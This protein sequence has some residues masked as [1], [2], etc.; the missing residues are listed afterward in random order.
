MKLPKRTCSRL[1][2]PRSPAMDMLFG[3][4]N[5]Y[6]EPDTL[7]Q[8]RVSPEREEWVVSQFMRHVLLAKKFQ[9]DGFSYLDL[10]TLG[11]GAYEAT[12][13]AEGAD[14]YT[15]S[16]ESLNKMMGFLLEKG[17]KEPCFSVPEV[18]GHSMR[19]FFE[20]TAKT[21]QKPRPHPKNRAKSL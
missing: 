7:Y 2:P 12:R 20:E 11:F 16:L 5:Q 6:F 19:E 21:P 18:M 4:I 10:S 8:P 14:I 13:R 9:K 1:P 3:V 17:G 15:V